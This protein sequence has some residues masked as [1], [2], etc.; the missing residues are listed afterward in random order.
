[1]ATSIGEPGMIA[2]V[3]THHYVNELATILR[4]LDGAVLEKMSR[5]LHSA[6]LSGNTVFFIGNGGSAATAN[7]LATDLTKL[8]ID[9]KQTQRLR[10]MALTESISTI[11]AIG[12]DMAYEE[13]FAEQLRSLLRK[14]DVI[15]GISTSGA[16]PNVVRAIEYG[17]RHGAL[18]M[19]VTGS[20]GTLQHI[21]KMALVIASTNVQKVE[22]ATMVAGHLLC[23]QTREKMLAPSLHDG[24]VGSTLLPHVPPKPAA[25]DSPAW[26]SAAP[27]PRLA[28]GSSEGH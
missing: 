8:T 1:V 26:G 25:G 17:N 28:V 15:V 23:L 27:E 19:S 2:R 7:H 9:P 22:D 3:D 4:T 16:S 24:V 6:F 14:D 10:A 5:A 11:S 12:N 18:T 13:I 20:G 21:A